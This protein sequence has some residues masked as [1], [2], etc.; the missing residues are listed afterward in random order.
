VF[1]THSHWISAWTRWP[2]A[3]S[4]GGRRC[5]PRNCR[6]TVG[7]VDAGPPCRTWC[8]RIVEH[9]GRILNRSL[10]QSRWPGMRGWPLMADNAGWP[11][12]LRAYRWI[13]ETIA[14]IWSTGN[15]LWQVHCIP[16]R[17]TSCQVLRFRSFYC[18]QL[19]H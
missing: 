6:Y 10:A 7:L 18:A 14:V 2:I 4:P 5:T 12:G 19:S 3:G 16:I 8:R 9:R 17:S 13:F 11:L 1:I 15:S